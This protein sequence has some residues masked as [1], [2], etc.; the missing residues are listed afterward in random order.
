MRNLQNAINEA[1]RSLWLLGF[2]NL[3]PHF[4]IDGKDSIAEIRFL[5]EEKDVHKFAG[6][7]KTVST[8]YAETNV[9]LEIHNSENKIII[10]PYEHIS[11]REKRKIILT[12]A[13]IQL[14]KDVENYKMKR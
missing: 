4:E 7:L 1:S 5:G 9:Q 6:Y 2:R 11:H 13:L 3:D 10:M 12:S 14:R 8:H